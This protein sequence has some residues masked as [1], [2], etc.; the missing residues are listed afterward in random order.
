MLRIGVMGK[1]QNSGQASIRS[2]LSKDLK[3]VIELIMWIY[4]GEAYRKRRYHEITQHAI[5]KLFEGE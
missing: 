1:F 5:Y 4:G 3:D 2:V